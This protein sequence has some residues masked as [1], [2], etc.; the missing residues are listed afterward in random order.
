MI[1]NWDLASPFPSTLYSPASHSG[2]YSHG[3]RLQTAN[4]PQAA[5]WGRMWP[6]ELILGDHIKK[7]LA[8][9]KLLSE[10]PSLLFP[11]SQASFLV[12][13]LVVEAFFLCLAG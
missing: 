3:Y 11:N 12:L 5:D 4:N 9:D 2:A 8:P 6:I 13:F 7:S 1:A 10:H